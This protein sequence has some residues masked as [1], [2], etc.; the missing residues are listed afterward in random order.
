MENEIEAV[1]LPIDGCID[2]HT[3]LPRDAADVVDEYIRACREKG[4]LEVRVIHGKGK[5][6]LRR[7]VHAVLDRHP[8]VDRYHLDP[9][10]SGWGAT[11]VYLR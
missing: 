10:P 11:I 2:L 3:F 8:M 5:G 7:T 4:I 9:G 1:E 6:T